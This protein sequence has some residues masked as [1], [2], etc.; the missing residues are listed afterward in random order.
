MTRMGTAREKVAVI[1]NSTSD[2]SVRLWRSLPFFNIYS[3]STL[4]LSM[5]RGMYVCICVCM[6]SICLCVFVLRCIYECMYQT[7]VHLHILLYSSM[8][9]LGKARV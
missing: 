6:R 7:N 8:H 3:E 1:I 2:P 5:W 9:T 4:F